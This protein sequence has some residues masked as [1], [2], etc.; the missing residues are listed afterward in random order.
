[1]IMIVYELLHTYY[2]H[3]GM[4]YLS[5]KR[6]GYYSSLSKVE[7]A[8][9]FYRGLSGFCDAPNGFIVKHWE[10]SDVIVDDCLYAALIYAHTEDFENYE[11][12]VD[13][14]LFSNGEMAQKALDLFRTE[15]TVFLNNPLLEIEYLVEKYIIDKSTGWIEGFTVE[16]NSN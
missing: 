1:M 12:D 7:N 9:S 4:L 2:V 11:Y 16:P 6:L 5:P 15:N 14:G 10:V 3:G 8:I 13:L